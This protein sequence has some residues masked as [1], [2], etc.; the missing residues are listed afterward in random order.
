MK[1]E[2]IV[3]KAVYKFEE[4][5]LSLS[6]LKEI[7]QI[8][9]TLKKGSKNQLLLLNYLARFKN[10]DTFKAKRERAEFK[11]EL[12]NSTKIAKSETTKLESSKEGQSVYA[13]MK[14]DLP[15]EK[16]AEALMKNP[17]LLLV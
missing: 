5:G 8:L 2:S 9:P 10:E 6:T 3:E 13:L 17:T 4:F 11:K 14:S 16:K 7:N 12:E 1:A 15:I